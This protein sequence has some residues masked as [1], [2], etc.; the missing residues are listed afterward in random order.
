[1]AKYLFW[2][3]LIISFY[4]YFGYPLLLFIIRLF[5][6]KDYK[7]NREYHPRVTFIISAFNEEDVIQKKLENSLSIEY[8]KEKLQIIVVSDASEDRTDEIVKGYAP[9][10]VKLVRL[11]NRNG[12]TYGL[13]KAM[14]EAT[15]EV[16]IFS[17]A[18]AMY[19]R[20]AISELVKYFS[21]PQ[22]GYAVGKA[23]YYEN[24]D[25]MA[26]K[27]ENLYWRY[28]LALKE[29]ESGVGSVVGGDGA[30]YAIRRKLYQPL[31]A[32]DIND[33]VN[34]L[35][36]ISKGYRG[37]FCPEAVCY[38]DAAGDFDKEFR[39]K[40]RIVNRSWRGLLKTTAALNPF[41][42]GIFAWQ[43][44]SH[45]ILRWYWWAFAIFLLLSSI[46][47]Y[48]FG[49]FYDLLIL[50]QLIFYGLALLGY[51]SHKYK[52]P[53]PGFLL[54]PFYFIEVHI[55]SMI[56]LWESLRGKKYQTW[57]TARDIKQAS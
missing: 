32:D 35:Q 16:V 36:I 49:R 15:G 12:K 46:P 25:K 22:V 2:F 55:A 38:E 48:G 33:F 19:D 5:I 18:N 27:Q 41:K 44:F 29:L 53:I 37:V 42:V 31:D 10:G 6:H 3:S 28:E 30:I 17:D 20:H 21:D 1:M 24:L 56:G 13:N 50:L 43:I 7:V 4:I 45:K 39:R 52:L 26:G 51:L 9:S 57:N 23:E 54:T 14:E 11:P 34:P 47:L 8:P 40:K